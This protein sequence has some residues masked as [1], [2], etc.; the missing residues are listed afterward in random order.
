MPVLY[1]FYLFICTLVRRDGKTWRTMHDIA[2]MHDS[3]IT[4]ESDRTR[5]AWRLCC[6]TR[7]ILGY[8]DFTRGIY[9][10]WV[11]QFEIEHPGKPQHQ[12]EYYLACCCLRLLNK[13]YTSIHGPLRSQMGFID[14]S[15]P[16]RTKDLVF[17]YLRANIKDFLHLPP[18]P[19]TIPYYWST[20]EWA[21]NY[22]RRRYQ[23]QS[24]Q[25]LLTIAACHSL[26]IPT[27]RSHSIL[28]DKSG[29]QYANNLLI[30]TMQ[31]L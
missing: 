7:A 25:T 19:I 11:V 10:A 28:R 16:P 13:S 22:W 1:K 14:D 24:R 31:S 4:H 26:R 8:F 29:V 6:R 15:P 18:T 12:V 30:L 9:H 5:C 2:V 20:Q 23:C 21:T 3:H 27:R 17:F